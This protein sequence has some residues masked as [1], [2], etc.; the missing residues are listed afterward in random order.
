MRITSKKI[1]FGSP[2]IPFN[3]GKSSRTNTCIKNANPNFKL[4]H[5]LQP[6][7]PTIKF[8]SDICSHKVTR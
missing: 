3:H 1:W 5:R 2:T 6:I 8:D 4:V 7:A